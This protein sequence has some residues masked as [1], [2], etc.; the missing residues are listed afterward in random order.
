MMT[1]KNERQYRI[2]KTQ[3]GKFEQAIFTLEAQGVS[4]ETNLLHQAQL[5]ALKSQRDSLRLEQT[6]YE[7]LT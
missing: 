5:D 3:A 6:E 2:T 1:I 4:E 7:A